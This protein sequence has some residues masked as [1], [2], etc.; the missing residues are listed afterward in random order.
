[1][2]ACPGRL[3]YRKSVGGANEFASNL[4]NTFGKLFG[5]TPACGGVVMKRVAYLIVSVAVAGLLGVAPAADQ[6]KCPI[7]GRPV[8]ENIFLVVN[9]KKVHFCCPNCPKAYE[10]KLRVQDEG[11]STCPVSGRPAKAEYR[12]IHVTTKKVAFCCPNCPNAYLKKLGLKKEEGKPGKCPISGRPAKADYSLVH[13][14]KTIY[15]CCPNCPKAYMKKHNV[16]EDTSGKC[17][18]S[19]RDADPDNFMLVT[20]A[21]AVYFCCPNCPKAYAKKH[22]GSGAGN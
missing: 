7:S 21:K 20:E 6:D 4:V 2:L 8:K 19:G 12:M 3:C 17:P 9:G 1:M 18:V 16:V 15:F 13:D 10:K 5:G 22:F 11:P 14:G